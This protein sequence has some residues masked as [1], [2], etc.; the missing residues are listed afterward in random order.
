MDSDVGDDAMSCLRS[1]ILFAAVHG[2]LF[3]GF[4]HA[5]VL[6]RADNV[7]TSPA[8]GS[9]YS[10]NPGSSNGGQSGHLLF[11]DVAIQTALTVPVFQVSKVTFALS[12][13]A[14]AAGV[15]VSPYFSQFFNDSVQNGGPFD[16]S[17]VDPLF[18]T[19]FSSPITL[20]PNDDST[21][22]Q[23]VTFGNGTSTLFNVVGAPS[24]TPGFRSF[25]IGMMLSTTSTDNGWTLAEQADNQDVLWDRFNGSWTEFTYGFDNN[26]L[27]IGTQ[28]AI[29]EG[30]ISEALPGDANFDGKVDAADLGA[31]AIHWQS[32]GDYSMG[33]FNFDGTVNV[34]DLIMLAQHWSGPPSLPALSDA[35]GL[36]V[37]AVPEP[38][39]AV[40]LIATT[41]AACCRRT[42]RTV[43]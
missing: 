25:G 41:S 18:P 15:Q 21:V 9:A 32:A 39:S 22:L 20:P 16:G 11:D 6:Y 24:Q 30:T 36:P 34:R 17:A 5:G 42:R 37:T 19:P 3:T 4:T 38:G 23:T 26:G 43:S 2:W 8:D 31:L 14:G 7:R 28:Y 13:S 10:Y 27:I 12:R 29:V 1:I 33:D 40:L 35:L